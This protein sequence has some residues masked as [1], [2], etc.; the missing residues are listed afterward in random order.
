MDSFD[1]IILIELLEHLND[2]VSLL[3]QI[4]SR[5]RSGGRMFI[6]TPCGEARFGYRPTFSYNV[7][8]HVQFWTKRSFQL[9]CEKAG[10]NFHPR[11]S[12]SCCLESFSTDAPMKCCDLRA[13]L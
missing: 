11:R 9:L 13:I 6:T 4:K 8:E 2:P 12:A 5:L 1:A 3:A 7:P 10:L